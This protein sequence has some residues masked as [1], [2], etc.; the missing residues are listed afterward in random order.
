LEDAVTKKNLGLPEDKKANTSSHVV[1][2]YF[3]AYRLI[4]FVSMF[5]CVIIVFVISMAF[6]PPQF[7]QSIVN[8]ESNDQSVAGRFVTQVASVTNQL[9]QEKKWGI[10]VREDEINAWLGH[11]LPRNHP[12]LLQTNLWGRLSRPRIKLEPQLVRIGIEVST[13]GVT[14]IAWADV[15]VK[16]KSSNQFTL[17]VRRAGVGQLPL[18]RNAI[19]EECSKTL[20]TAGLHTEM[21]RF[22]DRTLLLATVPE[23]LAHSDSLNPKDP[24]SRHWQVDSL[25]IDRGSVTVAG[26]SHTTKKSYEFSD[27]L[28]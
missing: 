5:G 28:P 21:Q 2:R 1:M 10:S 15:E 19:L 27:I 13:W 18:P 23:R 7:Y 24:E 14:A 12:E 20:K 6:V 17:T 26:R 3:Q 22:R 25:R 16:L 8:I 11:D 4:L 9:R